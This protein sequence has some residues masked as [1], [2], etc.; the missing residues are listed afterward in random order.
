MGEAVSEAVLQCAS[1]RAG[2]W[3][4]VGYLLGGMGCC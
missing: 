4:V 1:G 3:G 2:G